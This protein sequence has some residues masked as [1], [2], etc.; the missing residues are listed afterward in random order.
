MNSSSLWDAR[1]SGQMRGRST[2]Q[3]IYSGSEAPKIKTFAIKFPR[4]S[5]STDPFPRTQHT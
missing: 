2:E 5:T 3:P 4:N 1:Q